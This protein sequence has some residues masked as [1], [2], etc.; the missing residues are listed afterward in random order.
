VRNRFLYVFFTIC[1]AYLISGCST[2]KNTTLSRSYHNLTSKYNIFFNGEESYKRGVS[3]AEK[4]YVD[5]YTKIL[6]VFYYSDPEVGNLVAPD[7]TRAIQKATK[8]ITLH[9]ITAKPSFKR[10]PQTQKQKDF[11]NKKEYN[12]W[13]KNNLLL[14]G[15]SYVYK[16][17]FF[18]AQE[19]LR[20]IITDFP[21]EDIRFE[22]MIWMARAYNEQEEYRESERILTILRN[23][24]DLPKSLRDDLNITF[25]DLYIKQQNYQAAIPFLENALLQTYKKIYKLRYSYILAQLYEETSM[26]EQANKKYKDV[27]KMNPPY[28]MAF[29]ARINMAGT[30]RAGADN[31]KEIN[32]QLRKMLKDEKNLD[33]QDQIYYALADLEL[34]LENEELAIQYFKESVNSSSSNYNQK[35]LSYLALGD[36][37]YKNKDYPIAQ[38][39]YDSSLINITSDYENYEALQ[40]K[41]LSLTG[42]VENII[43]FQLQDSLQRLARMPEGERNRIVDQII[44]DIIAKEEENRKALQEDQLNL[45]YG[46]QMANQ[47]LRQGNTSAEG[48]WY[49]YNLNA[50]SFGQPEFRMI[51]GNR[52]IEDNWRR[53]N[54]QS[55]AV[56]DEDTGETLAENPDQVSPVTSNTRQREYYLQNIPVNQ[57]MLKVSDS[58]LS[59]SLFNMGLIYRSEFSDEQKSIESFTELL[60][61]YPQNPWE[62]PVYYNLY[63]LYAEIN[64]S[65]E[66]ERYKNLLTSKFPESSTSRMLTD[67]DYIKQL[68]ESRK[69]EFDFYEETYLALNN[70]EFNRVINNSQLALN[71]FEH[72]EL[73]PKFHLL[74]ALATGG[75]YGKEAMKTEMETI[76]SEY[77]ATDAANYAKEMIDY[78][79]T[80]APE[81]KLEDTRSKAEEIYTFDTSTAHYFAILTKQNAFVNQ[82]NFNII[83]F[84]LDYYNNM[85]LAIQREPFNDG[86]LFLIKSFSSLDI[87]RLY[88]D[89]F[90]KNNDNFRDIDQSSLQ[91]FLISNKNLDVLITDKDAQK[92]ILFFEK[93][94]S[95]N[96]SQ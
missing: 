94:Y 2:S 85:N 92:Y 70:S 15:K 5:N 18:L 84:N 61:R 53:K 42:L 83:N 66:S 76:V 44:A 46:N 21:N 56:F 10:G 91:I 64:Q 7:M 54:K 65:A 86:T 60:K 74:R 36:I 79:Y 27:I 11:Y 95:I 12:K 47:N 38:A 19:A 17:D 23:E 35:G 40:Q 69:K 96:N 82:L 34:K 63:E 25:T 57:E 68:E 26:Y 71:S 13:V 43:N 39:Y 51:W 4:S 24:N 62:L 37:Y 73:Y 67:P 77:P 29:N 22:A 48:K 16:R 81:I 33:F 87:A 55:I 32:A 52:R 90:L 14:M 20:K 80:E 72:K 28:E 3:K 41:T 31:A 6:P 45:Q 49:F 89:N 58:I 78:I 8:V 75:L 50:K 9:S 30:F 88:M 1:L 93:Y 59:E